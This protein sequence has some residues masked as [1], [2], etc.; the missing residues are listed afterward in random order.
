MSDAEINHWLLI[1]VC[2]LCLPYAQANWTIACLELKGFALY[3][4]VLVFVYGF[5]VFNLTQV[6]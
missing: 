2:V 3:Y 1:V 4:L 5:L 6:L